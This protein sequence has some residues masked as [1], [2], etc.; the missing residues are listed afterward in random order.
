MDGYGVLSSQRQRPDRQLAGSQLAEMALNCRAE[1]GGVANVQ[2]LVAKLNKMT[3]TIWA[4]G[5]LDFLA[6]IQNFRFLL[7]G[8]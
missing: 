4:D 3:V 2:P 1:I 8:G 5:E 6:A 7:P